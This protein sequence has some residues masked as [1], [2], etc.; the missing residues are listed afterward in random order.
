M[1]AIDERNKRAYVYQ[2]ETGGNPVVVNLTDGTFTELDPTDQLMQ[3]YTSD[4][5]EVQHGAR[6]RSPAIKV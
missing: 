4:A 1:I 2:T 6:A 5:A 3:Q